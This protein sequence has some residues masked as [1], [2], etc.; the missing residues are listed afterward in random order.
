MNLNQA[1]IKKSLKRVDSERVSF[2]VVDSSPKVKLGL[3][4]LAMLTSYFDNRIFW[5][6]LFCL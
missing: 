6:W 1:F 3:K 5:Q 4:N 2:G